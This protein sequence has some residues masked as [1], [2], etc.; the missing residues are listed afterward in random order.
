M[1]NSDTFFI[2]SSII[3]LLFTLVVIVSLHFLL[4]KAFNDHLEK[5]KPSG[6]VGNS[7]P[8]ERLI[9]KDTPSAG[10]GT[11]K[12]KNSLS[13]NYSD[14]IDKDFSEL[15]EKIGKEAER[16]GANLQQR[17]YDEDFVASVR[18]I[19]KPE[20]FVQ[21]N[22][23]IRNMPT[24]YREGF[25]T[26][27]LRGCDTYQAIKIMQDYK[28]DV[29]KFVKRHFWSYKP[30]VGDIDDLNDHNQKGKEYIKVQKR[31]V[32]LSDAQAENLAKNLLSKYC[33]R[34][35][36]WDFPEDLILSKELATFINQTL[37]NYEVD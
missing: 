12:P 32:Q 35:W 7:K 29:G 11:T 27:I 5:S 9:V 19:L 28:G 3:D 2:I 36:E 20:D 33:I 13:V 21:Y 23:S 34:R 24:E 31:I 16:A 4:K 1:H 26:L 18:K 14:V 22:R 30:F 6:A 10:Y 17:L 15:I 37:R 25:K 8:Q